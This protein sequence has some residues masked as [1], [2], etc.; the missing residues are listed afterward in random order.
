MILSPVYKFY[1]FIFIIII[2][3]TEL[4][5]LIRRP[6]LITSDFYLINYQSP[7][8]QLIIGPDL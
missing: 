6:I 5:N 2:R 8:N 3:S 4:P 7:L 1:L